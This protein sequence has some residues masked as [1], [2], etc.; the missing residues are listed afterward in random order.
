[1]LFN[2]VDESHEQV[3]ELKKPDTKED[4]T[5]DSIDLKVKN[6][7]HIGRVKNQIVANF[8]GSG[9]WAGGGGC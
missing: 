1:M 9:R 2:N 3:V 6:Y 4:S 5:Y 8:E 7:K